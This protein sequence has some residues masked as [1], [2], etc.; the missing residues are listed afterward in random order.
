MSTNGGPLLEARGLV[1]EFTVRGRGGVKGG[2]VHAV[3]DVS[4][5]VRP[6]ETL[7]IV[8]ET[9]SGKSTLARSV[10]QAPPPKDGSVM[11]RGSQLVGLKRGELLEARR[12]MQMVFQD[13]FGSLDPTWRVTELVEEPLVAHGIGSRDEPP[14]AGRAR[15]STSSGWIPTSTAAGAR[16][17]CRAA[18]R[19]ASRSPAR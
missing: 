14:G 2:V 4:F 12:H 15:C 6:G 7:G 5:E 16:A 9:G 18:R 3:S 8:G 1:Q 17:S 19:S 10:L 13:P 11:F